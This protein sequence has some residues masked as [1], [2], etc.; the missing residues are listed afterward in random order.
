MIEAARVI[1]PAS[2]A[3]DG[4]T[5]AGLAKATGAQVAIVRQAAAVAGLALP[6]EDNAPL[7][8]E[9]VARVLAEL[10]RAAGMNF[11]CR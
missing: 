8:G 1:H 11:I 9:T 10:S 4:M 6:V 7:D 2:L 3:L 5:A